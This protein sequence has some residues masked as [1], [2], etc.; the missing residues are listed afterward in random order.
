M[1]LWDA[2]LEG[3]VAPEALIELAQRALPAETDEQNVSRILGY[4]TLAYWRHLTP[5]RR[6]ELAPAIEAMLWRGTAAAGSRSRAA[7][8]FAAYRDVAL[9]AD[10]VARLERIWREE[11]E[12]PG[13][14]LAE[15]D[16]TA[17]AQGLA[18]RGVPGSAEI[19]VEQRDRV[20][21]PDRRTAFE[22]AMPAVAAEQEVR[23]GFFDS[24]ADP[25]NRARE[26]WV[27]TALRLLH[28]P[29]RARE[30]EAYI[31]PSLDLLEEI[32]RTGDIFFPLRW[33]HATL[34]GHQTATAAAIVEQY[35]ADRPDLRRGCAPRRCRRPTG[36]CARRGLST[37]GSLR[38][39]TQR[40]GFRGA[41]SRGGGGRGQHGVS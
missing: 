26:P 37:A 40:S 18:V 21:N 38:R 24:L 32:Q 17:L 3:E 4:L 12:V 11:E 27:L 7:A 10:A 35:L 9:S 30:S 2:L 19:L 8:W 22:F 1:S 16:F 33:L 14:P 34:D 36:C 25:A 20:D 5:E 39:R 31:R 23:D 29:L 13:V 15:R 6:V 28:H 41:G